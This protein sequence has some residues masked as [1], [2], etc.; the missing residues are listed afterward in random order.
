MKERVN[1]SVSKDTDVKKFEASEAEIISVERT[2]FSEVHNS[3]LYT[4]LCSLR[5]SATDTISRLI[6]KYAVGYEESILN[7]QAEI[8]LTESTSSGA[9]AEYVWPADFIRVNAGAAENLDD[10]EFLSIV[11][12]ELWHYVAGIK[13]HITLGLDKQPKI[14]GSSGLAKSHYWYPEGWEGESVIAAR[15]FEGLD[16]GMTDYLTQVCM[17]EKQL[18][19]T[20]GYESQVE[21][22]HSLIIGVSERLTKSYEEV[23]SIILA[24]YLNKD[25]LFLKTIKHAYGVEGLE[26]LSAVTMTNDAEGSKHNLEIAEYF[27]N[28]K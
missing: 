8:L 19:Y 28:T 27:K 20:P 1:V 7:I 15:H 16:E 4:H 25:L 5:D 17:Q 14:L 22:I 12:H 9:I 26:K 2:R 23:F 24:S 21:V 10:S 3:E 13:Q 11:T 6:H 18:D